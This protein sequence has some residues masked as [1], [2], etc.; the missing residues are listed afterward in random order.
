V[1]FRARD[2]EQQAAWREHLLGQGIHVSPVMERIYFQSI[3]FRSPDGLLLEIATDGPGFGVDEPIERLG[4]VL[5]LPAWLE[6]RRPTLEAALTTL[7]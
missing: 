7:S 5:A 2:A 3:Y 4:Q 1:A 6:E